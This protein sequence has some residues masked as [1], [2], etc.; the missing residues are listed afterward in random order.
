MRN[1]TTG[2]RGGVALLAIFAYSAMCT[3][4]D[5]V[6]HYVGYSAAASSDE[7]YYAALKELFR[8]YPQ[9]YGYRTHSVHIVELSG[10]ELSPYRAHVA[11]GSNERV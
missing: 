8:D 5:V 3:E 1:S 4:G 2:Q 11:G 7:A 6:H 9:D 10:V